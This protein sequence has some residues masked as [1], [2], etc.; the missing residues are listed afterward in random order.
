M[1]RIKHRTVEANGISMHV[2]EE[3][4]GPAVL[5]LHGFPELWYTWRHQ[6]RSLAARG[7]RAVAPDLR[8]YGDSSCPP[9]VTSYTVFHL[10]GDLVA[11]L[12]ALSLTEVFVVG[13]DWGA[14]VMWHLCMFR[15]DRVRAVVALS[16][17]F[18]P[19]IPAVNP[20]DYFRALYG[21]EYYVVRF[22]Q[23]AIAP[24]VEFARLGSRVMVKKF[25]TYHSPKPLYIPKEGWDSPSDEIT[26]PPWI[27]EEDIDYYAG[28]FDKSGFTGPINYYRCL[29]LN[30]E[31]TAAWSGA[32]VR[33]PAKFIT[34]DQDLTYHI[35][36]EEED[37]IRKGGFKRDV[38]FLLD[39]V[40]MRGVGHFI[41]EERPQEISDHI[42][43]FIRRF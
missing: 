23:E 6:M 37:Y 19:R 41:Q 36:G 15:P 14:I 3:G 18:L 4:D 8:G 38:P 26:L 39:V 25:L 1:E 29:N 30:W 11:L 20:V 27:S 28:K 12:D 10:A 40:V 35:P 17:P 21:D 42:Y 24:E 5:L 9:S 7:Y 31:L 22:F 13:H 2:A 43:D 34:G 33:V 32:K 16:V